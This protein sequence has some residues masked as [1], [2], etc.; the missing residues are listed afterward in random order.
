MIAAA[1][2]L[3][4][5]L[6]GP[7]HDAVAR[8]ATDRAR[9]L[10]APLDGAAAGRLAGAVVR[11]AGRHGLPPALILAVVEVESGYAPGAVSHAAC[12][13][14]MQLAPATAR[15]VAGWLGLRGYALARAQDSIALG[16]AY[17]TWLIRRYGRV[18]HGLTA[19]NVGMG[20]FEH[21]RTV[22]RYAR[23]V[24]AHYSALKNQLTFAR[25]YPTFIL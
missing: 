5:L 8:V 15:Q 25:T 20:T 10:G 19:Y 11:A 22:N 7:E 18:D 3:G 14:L 23:D 13:G 4:Y 12:V 17:L 6:L 2:L 21:H 16:T 1:A 24:L 9:A